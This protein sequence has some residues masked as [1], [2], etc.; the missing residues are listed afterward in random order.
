MEWAWLAPAFSFGAFGL[1]VILGRYIPGKGSP[2]AI[3]A[4]AGAFAVFCYVLWDFLGEGSGMY[5][6]GNREALSM[7]WFVLGADTMT[8]GMIID[9]LSVAMLGIVSIVAL[10]VQVYSVGYMSGDSRFGWYFAAHALFAGAMLALVLADNFLLLYIAW[11]LVGLGSYLL[12]GF[13]YERRSA[14]EAAKKAFVTTRLGD[15]GLLIGILILFRATGTF[16]MTTIFQEAEK[17]VAGH[18]SM[19][20]T[21]SLTAAAILI[22]IGAMGKS[23]QFPLHV[24][25]PD[26]MEGPT[27]VSAL[28]HA[29]TMVAAG[30]YLVARSFPIF[31]AVPSVT[32]IMA[33]V[34]LATAGMGAAVAMVMTDI[35]RIL[36]YSTISHLGLM[37]LA[38]GAGNAAVAIFHLLVHAFSKALL[39]LGAG[40]VMHA[41]NQETDIRKMGG[42]RH[43]MPITAAT[44]AVGAISLAGIPPLG[45]FFS[46]DE[47]LQ[48]V[49]DGRNPI[50]LTITL[51]IVFFSALYMARVTCLVF[52]GESKRYS[53][54]VHESPMVMLIPMILL[55]VGAFGSGFLVMGVAGYDG[56][57]SFLTMGD[58]HFE[59]N[60]I[61]SVV[62]MLIAVGGFGTGYAVYGRNAIA[63]ERL[64]ERYG[65]LHRLL[66]NKFYIDN[67][68]QWI[69]D[70]WVLASAGF[71]AVFDRSVVNDIVV[72]GTADTVRKSGFRIRYLETGMVYNYALSMVIGALVVILL[73]WLIIPKVA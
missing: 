60:I 14:T 46:K 55:A 42:L 20:S 45:G 50:F 49:L 56:F 30:V 44:F 40:S 39:F 38:L 58:H 26:A 59:F 7:T 32:L 71:V 35:K 66:V 10:L 69:I 36:A 43:Q 13:W 73:W 34:G 63:T 48:A 1:I 4:I 24:W 54:R 5:F 31:E 8:W 12:I 15:V 62:S 28:I 22:F 25:L 70:K 37:M 29:A 23:A 57:I 11:E 52:W 9:P 72:D 6:S 64:I 21:G 3:L 18:A 41:L 17:L 2:L 47:V 53:R 16:E 68:Y 19:L 51:A 33:V 27:P 61:L 65:S 67:I